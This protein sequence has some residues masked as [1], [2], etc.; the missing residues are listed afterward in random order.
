MS[1]TFTDLT[2]DFRHVHVP[3]GPNIYIHTVIFEPETTPLEPAIPL[4]M[5]HGFGC[6]IPQFYKNYDHLHSSR[7]VYSIDL[8]GYARSTRVKFTDNPDENEAMFVKYLEKWRQA[9]GLEKVILLGH[10]FGGYL[11]SSYAIQHPD[12]V[13]HLILD[14]PWGLL[15]RTDQDVEKK[16][17]TYVMLIA[18]IVSKFRPFDGVRMAG[19]AGE[20]LVGGWGREVGGGEGKRG[21][22]GRRE[23]KKRS[24]LRVK[25][26][27]GVARIGE[28]MAEGVDSGRCDENGRCFLLMYMYVRS[29]L[30]SRAHTVLGYDRNINSSQEIANLHYKY[31]FCS[32]G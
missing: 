23:K 20:E 19:P 9:V 21:V 24:G 3:V 13:R 32:N 6:G 7:R 30:F 27:S 12:R 17:P 2:S 29:H 4:V 8:P 28:E 18:H 15:S 10:S 11:C 5:V 22:A 26:K 14:D 25:G 1:S 16:F 31:D